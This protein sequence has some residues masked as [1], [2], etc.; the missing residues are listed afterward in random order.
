MTDHD[1]IGSRSVLSHSKVSLIIPV[2]N[3][4]AY[5][6]EC[7]DSAIAQTLEDLEIIC[8]NDGSTDASSDI[9]EE[10]S[11]LCPRLQVINRP[12]GGL[13]A[14]RNT[15]MKYASGDYIQFLDSDDFLELDTTRQ[16]YDA[17]AAADADIV[18]FDGVSFFES[19]ELEQTMYG[20]KS[21]YLRKKQYGPACAGRRLFV[22]MENAKE[23]RASACMQLIR[24]SFLLMH[25]FAF[26]EGILFEDNLFTFT[27]L[28]TAAKT[29]H[30]PAVLYHRR[31]RKNS[32]MTSQAADQ[33]LKSY[34]ICFIEMLHLASDLSLAPDEALSVERTLSLITGRA[35]EAYQKLSTVKDAK[36]SISLE[37][38]A[39]GLLFDSVSQ[40]K[41]DSFFTK[42]L[43]NRTLRRLTQ[44]L[45]KL[46]RRFFQQ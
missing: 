34:F 2:Y 24:R 31:V 9:L 6:R 4:A 1:A 19:P 29:M 35:K 18:F 13:S 25:G 42:L 10:Y 46:K 43:S 11:Q 17:A 36:E 39:F 27:C 44:P 40:Q 8:V 28:L 30:V 14:A 41:P 23:Y 26:Y 3:S 7:L 22:A 16:L 12:N 37:I 15:G 45:R 33:H 5:L 32:I 20:Y 21:Y 38:W